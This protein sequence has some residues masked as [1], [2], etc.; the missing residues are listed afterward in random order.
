MTIDTPCC[1]QDALMNEFFKFEGFRIKFQ[2][3]EKFVAKDVFFLTDLPV[4]D[5]PK[6]QRVADLVQCFV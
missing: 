6:V 2:I 5:R 1:G 3:P 4:L